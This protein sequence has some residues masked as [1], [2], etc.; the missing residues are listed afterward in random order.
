MR[1]EPS[2]MP[3]LKKEIDLDYKKDSLKKNLRNKY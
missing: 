2:I 3:V 1:Q